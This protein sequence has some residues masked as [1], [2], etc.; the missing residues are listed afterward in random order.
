ME[1]EQIT[2]TE[3][4]KINEIRNLFN[5]FIKD[6][7]LNKFKIKHLPNHKSY[8]LF[9][10]IS[11]YLIRYLFLKKIK[12]NY[13]VESDDFINKLTETT[14]EIIAY[15]SFNILINYSSYYDPDNIQEKEFSKFK[16]R[17]NEEISNYLFKNEKDLFELF[18]TIYILSIS[19]IIFRVGKKEYIL[20]SLNNFLEFEEFLSNKNNKKYDNLFEDFKNIYENLNILLKNDLKIKNFK[21]NPSLGLTESNILIKADADLILEDTLVEIKTSK[22]PNVKN[23]YLEQLLIYV[24]LYFKK[25]GK[26][27]K[28][29]KII[30]PRA[31][32]LITFKISWDK[33][34]YNN[35]KNT[36]NNFF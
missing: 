33:D 5:P 27:I 14:E 6:I 17:L 35:F 21:L 20:N 2:A 7:K 29:F 12:E 18:K 34:L 3:L 13:L 25:T 15:K 9:G 32:N 26:I 24:L 31:T 11:D 23:D 4:A 10:I 36:L 8:S 1:K 16:E 30:N 28:D 19:D 22:D